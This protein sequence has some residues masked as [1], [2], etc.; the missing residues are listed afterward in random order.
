MRR[1][2]LIGAE[3]VAV[4]PRVVQSSFAAVLRLSAALLIP[5]S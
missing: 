3:R 2:A 1:S 4:Y 5:A